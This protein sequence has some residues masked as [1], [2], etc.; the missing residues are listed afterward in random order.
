MDPLTQGLL[1]GSVAL[2]IADKP[3]TRSAAA[4]GFVAGMLADADILISSASDP[5][6]NIEFHRHFTHSLIFIPVGALIAAALLWPFMR[7]HLQF[8]QIYLFTLAGYATSGLIDA[9]TSYGTQLL[10]PF[11]EIRVAWSIISIIDPVFSG[12]LFVA[13]VFALIRRKPAAIRLGLALA[14]AYLLLGTWQH[15]RALDA[16]ETIAAQRGHSIDQ[17]LVKP[18]LANLVLWRSVYLS[19]ENFH[20]DAIR[21]G[22]GPPKLYPGGTIRRFDRHRDRPDLPDA[23]LLAADIDRFEKLSDGFVAPDPSRENVLIDIR[24][25]MMPT[26][27]TPIWGIDLNP[28]SDSRHVDFVN[29]RDRPPGYREQFKAMLLGRDLTE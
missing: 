9:C 26:G 21:I 4:C 1:G 5:L 12:I 14:G 16:A 6:L 29:Y 2:S 8:L 7:K 22:L 20:V 15:H 3:R 19:G 18:T 28:A 10:W 25:S 17:I 23:S 24:Y 13:I 11:S 27:L